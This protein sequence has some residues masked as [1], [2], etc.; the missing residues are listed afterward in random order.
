MHSRITRG[1]RAAVALLVAGLA[2]TAPASAPAKTVEPLNQYVISGK[3]DTDALAR[4]GFDL[5]EASVTGKKGK[6]F[7]VATPS[8]ARDLAKK[9]ATVTTPF[10]TARAFAA[11]TAPLDQP[12][13]G[14]NVFRPWS[15][16]PA[17]CPQTCSTPLVNLKT[18][19]HQLAVKNPSVVKEEVIGK[20]ILG[21]DI[22]AYKVTQG[23]RDIPDGS[24]PAVLYNS[25]QHAREWIST[26][27]E[28]R[29]FKYLLDSSKQT[30]GEA[31]KRLLQTRELWFVPVVNPDGYDYTFVNKGSRLWRKNLRD[32]NGG[33][34]SQDA[35]GVDTNRNWPTNW[36]YDLEG[37]S[38]DPSNETFHGSGPGSEPEVQ[39]MRGLEQRI[40]FKFS[41]DYH[42]FAQLIL[43]PEGWQVETQASDWPL[44]T[45]LAGDDDKPAV[46]GFDPDVSAELYTTNGD[47]TDD[48]LRAFG[49]QAYTVELDGG[50]GPDVG[51]TVDGPDSFSPGGFVY[52]DSESDIQAEF[53]KNLA[54]VLDL[55]RSAGDPANPSSHLGNTA[56]D[57]VPTT[58]P[59]SY[60]DPQTVEVDAKKSLGAVRVYWQVGGGAVRSAPTTEYQGGE[61]RYYDPG[62]YYHHLR[63]QV[64]GTAPGDS[65]KVWFAAG[66]QK[67][68][69]FTYTAKNESSNKVLLMAAEDTTGPSA[70][71]SGPTPGPFAGYYKQA[72]E[73]AG[74][75]YDV[76]DVD[77]QGRTAATTLGVLR[78]YK[79]VIWETG[80]DLYV[81]EPGQ[82]GG[83]GVSRLLDEEIIAAR[84]YMNDGGKLLVAGKYALQGGWDQLLY[85]PL[86]APPHPFCKSNQTTGNGDADDPPGQNF[87]CV[88]TSNDFQQYWLGAYL[89]ITLSGN[90]DSSLTMTESPLLGS[91]QFSLNGDDSAQN[92]DNLYSFLTTSSI[93]PADKYPQFRSEQAITRDGPPA[94]DPPTGDYYAY[95]QQASSAYKRLSRTVDLTGKTSGS[96]SFKVSYDTEPNY[97]YVMVEAHTVGQE[98]WTTLPDTNG[99]TSDDVGGGCPDPDP[100]WL[101]ENPFLGHYLTRTGSGDTTACTP[102]GSS[103]DWNAATGNS[104]GFQDWNVDLSAYAGSRVEVS[105]T[106]VTDPA[107]L[108]LG[109]FVDDTKVVADGA[110]VDETSFE[111]GLGG[112]S[113]PGAPASSGSN[114]NDW[115]RTKSV[116]F[117]DGPG[118][119]TG[120]SLYWGFGLEGVTGAGNRA[121]LVKDA[122][123]YLGA[124]G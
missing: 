97:D 71:H 12:T 29:T 100:F 3:V 115:I 48:A 61:R 9:G 16:T 47:V 60:G 120:H 22:M 34:F 87:N 17:P 55:A 35:D 67:S 108:G 110:T 63:G 30:D 90:P 66:S 76:Y 117:V 116:G 27:V 6:F 77:A 88:V 101:N 86:G 24:R 96:L 89:P 19:Y 68:D 99:H 75:P 21:Q 18:Y 107:V 64:S 4:A 80:D 57:F 28:R 45:A 79:A 44:M 15:L 93:L 54:F 5:R 102:H 74:V 78:H 82:P 103:G 41:I 52:Q 124:A 123:T 11:P 38:N 53:Q 50:S 65:V 32:V 94:F 73:D 42:S 84:D 10:G 112:W 62:T 20:S 8:Q 91:T 111:D 105:I 7:I 23:A 92:Q 95:S 72:L 40:K 51:G 85:N 46:A 70:D 56:P 13:H 49:T 118:V 106:H 31:I 58:F 36:N 2:A 69:S 119:A 121:R 122:M 14:Y 104:A 83:T 39:A 1:A 43:Y 113:V 81:R 59:I 114:Q 33:G 25:T 109:V 37:A 98:D 26:E